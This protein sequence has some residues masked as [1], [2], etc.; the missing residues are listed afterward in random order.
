MGEAAYPEKS[1][2][3][4]RGREKR[5]GRKG[6]AVAHDDESCAFQEGEKNQE[7]KMLKMDWKT[8]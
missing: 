7:K 3:R 1:T 5:R 6:R 4:C 2:S 8:V